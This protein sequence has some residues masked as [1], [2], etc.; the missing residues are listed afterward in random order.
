M[1]LGSDQWALCA[2]VSRGHNLERLGLLSSRG[3]GRSAPLSPPRAKVSKH[4]QSGPFLSAHGPGQPLEPSRELLV[5]SQRVLRLVRAVSRRHV[6]LVRRRAWV[7]VLPGQEYTLGKTCLMSSGARLPKRVDMSSFTATEIAYLQTQR[8]GR[9][10]TVGPNAEPHVAPVPFRYNPDHD[11][12]DVGGQDFTKRKKYHDVQRNPQVAIVV[13]DLASFSPWIE[14][15][16][17]ILGRLR[18]SSREESRFW[19]L[20]RMKCSG[21]GPHGSSAGAL[22]RR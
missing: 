8:L 13:D 16:I 15:G 4:A 11:T 3:G 18:F 9:L 10:G 7:A 6:V 12:I 19:T 17:E 21:S 5:T 20:S 14:R 2:G 22:T 1:T